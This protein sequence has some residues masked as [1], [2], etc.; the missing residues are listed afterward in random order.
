MRV[1]IAC[2]FSGTVRRAFRSLG[3]DA[4]SC[5]ILPADDG[6][7]HHYQDDIRNVLG[8]GKPWNE[9]SWDLMIAHPPCTYLTNSGVTWLHRDPTRWQK[10]D[11]AA[12]FFKMLLDAPI[13]RIAI[14]N[15]IMHKY[16]KERI[17]GVKQ[18]QV[19]Q[20]WMF[21][22]TESK[23]T[24]LWLKNLPTLKETK[25]VKEEMLKL[26]DSERQRLHWL[27]PSAD[28]WKLRST[29]YSGIADA[30]AT[31]WGKLL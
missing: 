8:R 7:E 18:S 24:C 19:I 31:Q 20:P 15:P 6:S 22:H 21:G 4:W 25:N 11:E 16:A 26:P 14:E 13:P 3:H 29:T 2:E 10:L 23:A 5:D 28:R 30:M 1:L 12:E 9:P 17:G 27:P